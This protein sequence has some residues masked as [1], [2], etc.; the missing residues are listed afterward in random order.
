MLSRSQVYAIISWT[1]TVRKVIPLR[2]LLLTE[3]LSLFTFITVDDL[4]LVYRTEYIFYSRQ[5]FYRIFYILWPL[6][7]K[8]F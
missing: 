4:S 5:R 2:S 6:Q 8:P 3:F 7:K 1:V